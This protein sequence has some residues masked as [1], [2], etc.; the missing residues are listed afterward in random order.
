M[1]A[2]LFVITYN[3]QALNAVLYILALSLWVA[4]QT[5]SI[6]L[7]V[8]ITKEPGQVLLLL[9]AVTVIIGIFTD[10]NTIKYTNVIST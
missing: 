7:A 9:A 2:K 5:E 8:L 10:E 1:F 4:Q 6:T 3:R